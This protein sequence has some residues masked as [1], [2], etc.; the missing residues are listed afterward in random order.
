MGEVESAT[1]RHRPQ[2]YTLEWI[3]WDVVGG[4]FLPMGVL[5]NRN[6]KKLLVE[7]VHVLGPLFDFVKT[8]QKQL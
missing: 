1:T 7:N 6:E 3:E 4:A 8:L 2:Y 5:T